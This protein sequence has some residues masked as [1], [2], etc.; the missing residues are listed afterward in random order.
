MNIHPNTTDQLTIVIDFD[1][2][3]TK[4]EG[5]DELANIAL[6]G[7]SKQADIVGKIRE[8]TDK[9]MVGEYSFADS[10]RDR[11]AL[12]PANR[13]HVDQLIQFL[14][15]KISESFKRNK[16]FLAE[17]ADQILIV[18]SGFKDF[19]VP[20]VEEMGIAADHVYANTFTYDESGEI[21]GY[22]T[23]NLLS[24]DRGKV[25]LLQSLAL[26]GE[27]HQVDSITSNPGHCLNLGIFTSTKAYSVAERLRA[28]DMFNGWGIRTLSSLSPAYNPM[29][30][31]IGSVWPHDNSMIAMGLRS[32]GLIDQSLELFQGLFN[33][34]SKQPYQRPPEL[35]CG[36]EMN[37]DNS[38][39][40]YPVA[41]SPQAWATG[42]I[43]QLL[44]MM[45]NLVPDAQNNCL[46]IIDPALPKSINRLSF[47][48]LRVGGTVLDLE[49]ERVG[50]TTAC[51]V[52]KKRGNL[53]VVIEA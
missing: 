38:P 18:S 35:F 48:N 40:Q 3:F 6:Q 21:T 14:K 52:A 22:D 8:I 17:F 29:G 47:H 44:Q 11:V 20:V 42:S 23:S 32:L 2:T 34:T 30:Y 24:Q 41:C 53:R 51:R 46:R 25:K 4:V 27:G 13:S 5:L 39:V 45:V 37:G 16:P 10:L 7:S 43:F 28:P 19:I 26:D 12:L 50:S 31:H 36:Y 15:G 33:M 9:G 1:S 49:F